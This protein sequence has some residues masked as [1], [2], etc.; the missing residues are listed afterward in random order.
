[1][2]LIFGLGNP[3]KEYDGTRHNVGF[4]VV[5]RLAELH[6]A[7][8]SAD[9]DRESTVAKVHLGDEN[10]LLA[11]PQTFM[12]RSGDAVRALA[13]YYKVEPKDILIV[14]DD[15]D[16]EPGRVKTSTDSGAAGHNGVSDV[17][18][19]MKTKEIPRIR[20]GVGRPMGGLSAE[21]WVLLQ[22]DDDD[23]ELIEETIVDAVKTVEDWAKGKPVE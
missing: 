7:A 11:K 23:A 22:P 20:I 21:T 5:D 18:E 8:W 3:G 4:E 12:N 19:K 2:K 6:E 15:M 1:M 9:E 10:T 17:H 16:L 13:S 14:H